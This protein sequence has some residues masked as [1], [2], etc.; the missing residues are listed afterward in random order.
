MSLTVLHGNNGV[1]LGAFDEFLIVIGFGF[2]EVIKK[3]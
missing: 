3:I 1:V 2:G